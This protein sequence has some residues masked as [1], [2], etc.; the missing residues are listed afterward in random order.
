MATIAQVLRN[1]RSFSL[2]QAAI[3]AVK[4]NE[5]KFAEINREQMLA[6]KNADGGNLPKYVDDPYFKSRESALRYEAWKA[7]ISPNAQKP[8]GVMDFYIN[9]KFHGTVNVQTSG[10]SI[11]Y[12]TDSNIS[13][14]VDSK[15]GGKHL[16]LS[17]EYKQRACDE[18]YRDAVLKK[19]HEGT[20]L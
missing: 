20:K 7:R 10:F 15:T 12:K 3:E 5:E 14:S 18:F 17:L 19:V 11:V 4:E 13:A 1:V 2:P 9:G 16:G 8:R 6:G